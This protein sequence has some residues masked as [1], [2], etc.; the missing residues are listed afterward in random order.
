MDM[1]AGVVIDGEKTLEEM[2]QD[3]FEAVIEVAS[4]KPTKSELFGMGND[5]FVVWWLGITS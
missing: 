1:N 2:G 3:I 4:G 5:E